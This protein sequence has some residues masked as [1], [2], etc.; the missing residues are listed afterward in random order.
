MIENYNLS[1]KIIALGRLKGMGKKRITDFL[2]EVF[3]KKGSYD[4]VFDD[5]SCSKI[6]QLKKLVETEL[7]RSS[8]DFQCNK[9]NY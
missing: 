8:W 5:F 1:T 7:T 9:G 6:N 3:E 4:F 2:E